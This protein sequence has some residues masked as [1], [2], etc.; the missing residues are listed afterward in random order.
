M[1]KQKNKHQQAQN[2]TLKVYVD[3]GDSQDEDEKAI[4]KALIDLYGPTK[5]A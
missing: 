4:V 1:D 2:R 5:A 3:Q